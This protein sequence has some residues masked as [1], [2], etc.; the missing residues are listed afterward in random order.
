MIVSEA[1]STSTD[2]LP[3][4]M[5]HTGFKRTRGR[6]PIREAFEDLDYQ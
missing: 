4:E 6:A 1:Y 5:T 2:G 3:E